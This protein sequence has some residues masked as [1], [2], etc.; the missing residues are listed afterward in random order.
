LKILPLFQSEKDRCPQKP[1][2]RQCAFM[3]MVKTSHSSRKKETRLVTPP[4]TSYFSNLGTVTAYSL[5]IVSAKKLC[6]HSC[7]HLPSYHL[8]NCDAF[9]AVAMILGLKQAFKVGFTNKVKNKN[10]MSACV[11]KKQNIHT[12]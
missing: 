12:S 5:N 4:T 2:T 7:I 6:W 9:Y 8:A 3:L 1:P 11:K 10:K